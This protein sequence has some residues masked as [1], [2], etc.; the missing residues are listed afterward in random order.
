MLT[1]IDR[2]MVSLLRT[3]ASGM[4][5]AVTARGW[6]WPALG[7]LE[8]GFLLIALVAAGLRLWEL[9]GRVMHYDEAI[10]LHTPGNWPAAWSSCTRRG[11]TGRFRLSWW[12]SSCGF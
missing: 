6:R 5:G 7:R 12:R 10:H 3:V 8:W 4:R 1:G 9:D 2:V 11:C